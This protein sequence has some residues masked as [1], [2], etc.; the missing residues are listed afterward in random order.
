MPNGLTFARIEYAWVEQGLR[1]I[2][3][4]PEL[5]T[6]VETHVRDLL[7]VLGDSY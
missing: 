1:T 3:L 4:E 2:D 5:S 6:A 7:G